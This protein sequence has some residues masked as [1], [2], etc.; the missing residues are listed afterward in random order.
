MPKVATKSDW[1]ILEMPPRHATIQLGFSVTAEE[2]SFIRQGCSRRMKVAPPDGQL[3]VGLNNL[4]IS[5]E[6]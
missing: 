2:M 3:S 1:P 4:Y 6:R 5:S